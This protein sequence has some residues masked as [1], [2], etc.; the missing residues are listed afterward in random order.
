MFVI[1]RHDFDSLENQIG[2]AKTSA[3]VGVINTESQDIVDEWIR[4]N[5]KLLSKYKGWDNVEYPYYTA[6]KTGLLFSISMALSASNS[7][8]VKQ[9]G[10]SYEDFRDKIINEENN[11][12]ERVKANVK[13][14]GSEM[15]FYQLTKGITSDSW[16]MLGCID[17]LEEIGYIKC[18]S[19]NGMRRD[20][21]YQYINHD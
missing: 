16:T 13:K 4:D 14:D 12:F 20:W 1:I 15:N 21:K 18:V 6:E 11:K 5:D 2:K 8:L 7:P 9:I 3:I 19:K 17:R 10:Y